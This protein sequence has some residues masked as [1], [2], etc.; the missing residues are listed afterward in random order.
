[1]YDDD[2]INN[3]NNNNI[4]IIIIIIYK[5]NSCGRRRKGRSRKICLRD[6]SEGPKDMEI[7]NWRERARERERERGKKERKEERKVKDRKGWEQ[8]LFG[9]FWSFKDLDAREKEKERDIVLSYL[10]RIYIHKLLV[11]LFNDLFCYINRFVDPCLGWID[12]EKERR[13]EAERKREREREIYTFLFT[14]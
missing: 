2:N 5:G 8:K 9:R 4:L 3:N 14:V 11:I 12:S 10:L 1:M 7:K 6:V 13:R